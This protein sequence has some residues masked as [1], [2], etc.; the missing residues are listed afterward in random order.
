MREPAAPFA[1]VDAEPFQTIV[2]VLGQPCGGSPL[3]AQDEHSDAP[4]LAVALGHE[5]DR[6]S[7]CGRRP[8]GL[9]DLPELLH[10]ARSE[11][12]QREVQVLPRDNAA[13]V[14]VRSLPLGQ[15]VERLV[16]EAEGAE[17]ACTFKTLHASREFHTGSSRFCSR[18][19]RTRCRAVIVAQGQYRV[20]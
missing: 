1:L 3:V 18:S 2:Q 11:E 10:R 16:G 9:P 13:A 12:G 14:D 15:G 20:S 17:Q 8:Q 5:P 4:G 7:G 6:R 19:L